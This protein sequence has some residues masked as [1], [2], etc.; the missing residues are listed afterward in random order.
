M[1]NDKNPVSENNIEETKAEQSFTGSQISPHGFIEEGSADGA[2]IDFSFMAKDAADAPAISPENAAHQEEMRRFRDQST[3]GITQENIGGSGA[4]DRND[5]MAIKATKETSA[6]Y[7][8][9]VNKGYDP[10]AKLS[11]N[12]KHFFEYEAALDDNKRLKEE[13]ESLTESNKMLLERMDKQEERFNKLEEKFDKLFALLMAQNGQTPAVVTDPSK[14]VPYVQDPTLAAALDPNRVRPLDPLEDVRNRTFAEQNKK[15]Q[16]F[17]DQVKEEDRLH[18]PLNPANV[19]PTTTSTVTQNNAPTNPELQNT[20]A[21]EAVLAAEAAAKERSLKKATILGAVV[22]AT[23][24]IA[25]GTG[26]VVPAMIV[27]AVGG[28]ASRGLEWVGG[29]R[30]T[31]LNEKIAAAVANGDT[32]TATKLDKRVKNWDKVR[33]ACKYVTRFFTGGGIG[34]GIG[35]LASHALLGG[36]GLV[37]NTPEAVLPPTGTPPTGGEP[38]GTG[39]GTGPETGPGTSPETYQGN[40][41]IDKNGVIHAGGESPWD[42]KSVVGPEGNLPGGA[43]NA[44]N[45]TQ[46]QWGR[47]PSVVNEFLEQNNVT[48]TSYLD[49]YDRDRILDETWLAMKGGDTN[50][51]IAG[52]LKHIGTDGTNRLLSSVSINGNLGNP[53]IQ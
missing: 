43:E 50:P 14:T 40:D 52:I 8:K 47:T 38:T 9:R 13:N 30:I 51:D 41:F 18:N 7:E 12:G 34:V 26:V 44:S 17:V 25:A 6:D 42:G 32:E 35:S 1:E 11:E 24:V 2:P 46:G 5:G 39:G 49:S 33:N 37:W 28:L 20:T 4:P 31:A 53:G 29:K 16:E 21:A 19:R 23:T 3:V 45:Y 36:H 10:K 22:G 27:C 15:A 48:D